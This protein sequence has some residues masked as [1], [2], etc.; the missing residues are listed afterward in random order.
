MF[1][2]V[3]TKRLLIWKSQ[4]HY[5]FI[6]RIITSKWDY[7]SKSDKNLSTFVSTLANFWKFFVRNTSSALYHFSYFSRIDYFKTW[8]SAWNHSKQNVSVFD[9]S[10]P[11]TIFKNLTISIVLEGSLNFALIFASLI[12]ISY[13]HSQKKIPDGTG[14]FL[15]NLK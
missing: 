11:G 7:F 6:T 12:G 4:K 8:C 13:D 9:W 3:E 14:I 15:M 1:Y 2:S 10:K 5:L